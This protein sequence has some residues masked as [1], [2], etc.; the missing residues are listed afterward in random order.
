MTAEDVA[1]V[2]TD[3]EAEAV[4][5]VIVA[6]KATGTVSTRTDQKVERKTQ[7]EEKTRLVHEKL[8]RKRGSLMAIRRCKRPEMIREVSLVIERVL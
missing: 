4:L 8:K 3:T 7:I 6:G 1:G 5:A 2:V